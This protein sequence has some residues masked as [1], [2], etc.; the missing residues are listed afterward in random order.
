MPIVNAY[1]NAAALCE[2]I[3]LWKAGALPSSL[4]RLFYDV[5]R[6]TCY[7]G[8]ALLV[9][10][11]KYRKRT[12]EW[13]QPDVQSLLLAHLL[14]KIKSTE[15]KTDE[16]KKVVNLL[17]RVIQNRLR[18]LHAYQDRRKNFIVT[19]SVDLDDSGLQATDMSGQIRTRPA[20]PKVS[21]D[22]RKK[23]SD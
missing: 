19:A 7:M 18:D 23:D 11:A 9:K 16:P 3:V 22:R 6:S 10:E 15:L 8:T 20:N 4:E 17:L 21:T 2:A 1:E 5:L 12:A 14:T 13:Q